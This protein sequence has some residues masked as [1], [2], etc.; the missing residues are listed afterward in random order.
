MQKCWGKMPC[1]LDLLAQSLEECCGQVPD[2]SVV[3]R[4][5]GEAL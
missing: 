3:E 5:S 1:R 4:C 2:K